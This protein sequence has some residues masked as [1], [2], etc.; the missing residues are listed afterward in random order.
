MMNTVGLDFGTHQT[1][2]CVESAEENVVNYRFFKFKDD[3]LL[4]HYTLP[5]IILIDE[6]NRLTY[7][8][9]PEGKV[10]RVVRY[11]KQGT[12]T[13]NPELSQEEATLYSIWYLAYVI[14]LLEEQYGQ[15]FAIQMGVPTDGSLFNRQKQL[16]TRILLS[17]YR[18]V[19][20]VFANDINRFLNTTVA[21]LKELTEI[22]PFKKST[23]EEFGINIF[24]E[25]Y[26]CLLPLVKHSKIEYGMSL[27]VDIGGGTTDISFFTI[28]KK[29]DNN[30]VGDAD[31]L[32]VYD[33]YSINKGLNFLRK[34]KAETELTSPNVNKSTEICPKK[35][36]LLH[37]DLERVQEKIKTKLYKEFVRQSGLSSYALTKVINNRPI[38]YSGGGSRFEMMRN[39]I[40]GF[41]D[42]IHVS[43]KEWRENE[44]EDIA[45]I[46]A[47]GLCPILSTAY[48]LSVRMK[49]DNV[50]CEPF[51][52]IF[53]NLRQ[54][55][56]ASR[57]YV[58][59]RSSTNDSGF[60][61][62]DY[63][64]WK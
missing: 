39:S 40:G 27:M 52:E 64:A 55:I 30:T 24:P 2:V 8:Y 14:F 53:R 63:D 13:S 37:N 29:V 33:F 36:R 16:A 59:R 50:K 58:P 18:L 32:H 56:S 17:A 41:N 26:S 21:E 7:G 19:E 1:K 11:F 42:V 5:S 61:Y 28:E 57:R 9:I 51:H 12:F 3:N 20:E 60:S 25:A 22:V 35:R 49:N 4:E 48:G 54:T 44:V 6:N 43:K 23:K 15:N 34:E 10:G 46:D 45:R 31:R 62:E 47:L 38:I